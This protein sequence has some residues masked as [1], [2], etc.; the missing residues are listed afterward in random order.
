ML[1]AKVTTHSKFT[2]S[3][4]NQQNLDRYIQRPV[5][6]VNKMFTVIFLSTKQEKY[7]INGLLKFLVKN[8][9]IILSQELS[10]S[11]QTYANHV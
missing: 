9:L 7:S 5:T 11:K 6:W 1:N 2:S 8:H 4:P 10:H 3:C